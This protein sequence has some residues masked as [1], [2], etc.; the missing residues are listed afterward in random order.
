MKRP[1]VKTTIATFLLTTLC[2][3]PAFATD[4]ARAQ[5]FASNGDGTYS[6]PPLYADFPDPDIIRVGD[7]FYF[8]TT[9]FANTPGLTILH[10]RDLVHWE[11]TGHVMARLDGLDAYDLRGGTAYRAGVYAPS[12][13]YHDGVFY[14]AVTPNGQNTRIYRA[15]DVKGPWTYT[16]LDR[17]AFDPGLFFDRDGTGY[18]ATS[19]G[20]DG[21]LTLLTLNADYSQ[22][23]ASKAVYYNKGAEGS[24]LI[25]RGEWYYLFNA[26]PSRLSLTVSR[27]RSLDGPWETHDQIDDRTGGHQGALVDLPNGEWYGF[28]MVDAGAIGRMTR[29]SPIFWQ[30][31]WPVWGTPAAPGRVPASATL[32]LPAHPEL[33]LATSD[34]FDSKVLGLQWQWNHNPDDSRWTLTE[35]P[36]FLRLKAT[37]SDAFW[38]ARN[39]LTQ[40][41]FG[42]SSQ[43]IVRLDVGHLH[44]GDRCGIGTLGKFNAQATV[45]TT[46]DGHRSLSLRLDEDTVEGQ[47]TSILAPSIPLQGDILYLRTEMDFTT[48]R[49]QIAY[50]A[51]GA[52]WSPL[53]GD[54]PLAYDWRTGTFQGPQFAMF[55]FNPADSDGY[56]DIDSFDLMIGAAH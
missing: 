37:R 18:I 8:A 24:K 28:V 16:E 25:H 22:I 56:L 45:E 9:T 44:P 40:K 14:I 11:Y 42:P 53:G 43:A 27:A 46:A 50:G 15:T 36:G 4:V 17:A 19:G 39:T 2:A 54:F 48:A 10:S 41:G 32:P 3:S 34:N 13:R 20:W 35:R 49:G 23:A 33:R 21:T 55:C 1:N 38:T 51:D 5:P 52:A 29:I 30:D 26:I 47:R 12:L 31:D 7:D 6:N